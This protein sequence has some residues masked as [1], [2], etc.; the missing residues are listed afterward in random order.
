MNFSIGEEKRNE[1][2]EFFL[3]FLNFGWRDGVGECVNGDVCN[4]CGSLHG[5]RIL[6]WCADVCVRR[7]LNMWVEEHTKSLKAVAWEFVLGDLEVSVRAG[8]RELWV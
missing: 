6:T 1:N 3:C 4:V 5:V 7:K 2:C 8:V